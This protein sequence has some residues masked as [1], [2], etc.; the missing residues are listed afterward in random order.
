MS[1]MSVCPACDGENPKCVTTCGGM[2]MTETEC[3]A[4]VEY[5]NRAPCSVCTHILS[6][7]VDT[8][9]DGCVWLVESDIATPR[10]LGSGPTL[11]DAIRA[12]AKKIGA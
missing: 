12:A 10:M 3:L 9:D 11:F 5:I 4:W 1:P 7:T 8:R 2:P 6:L